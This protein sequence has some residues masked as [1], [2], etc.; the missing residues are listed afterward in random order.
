VGGGDGGGYEAGV[1]AAGG[2]VEVGRGR[3]RH[4]R[5]L[6]ENNV[7]SKNPVLA[8]CL[9]MAFGPLAYAYTRQWRRGNL[10]T[11]LY[12]A[13]CFVAELG[14]RMGRHNIVLPTGYF[15]FV[16]S[17]L[18]F[19]FNFLFSVDLYN[20]AKYYSI[21]KFGKSNRRDW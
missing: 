5:N 12:L 20:Q 17:G 11:L 2:A 16:D 18:L 15:Y 9:G 10:A 14:F 8:A 19:A 6:K 4:R 7:D 1:R 13:A 3:G 21:R